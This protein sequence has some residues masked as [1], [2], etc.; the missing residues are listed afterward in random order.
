MTKAPPEA[1][2]SR[3]PQT[4]DETRTPSAF[5]VEK[6]LRRTFPSN[7][8]FTTEEGLAP[9][10]RLLIAYS[11]RNPAVGYCQSMNFLAAVLL[12]HLTEEQAFWVLAALIEDI[13]P[14]DYYSVS[15]LGSRVDQQVFQSCLAWKL[16]ALYR[17][18]KDCGMMLEPVTCSWLMC[19]YINTLP[20]SIV[21][22]VWDCLLWEGNIV[23]LRIGLAICKIQEEK[24]FRGT[25]FVSI[26]RILKDPYNTS[27]AFGNEEPMEDSAPRPGQLSLRNADDVLGAAFDKKWLGSLPRAKIEHLRREF[28]AVMEKNKSARNV[29]EAAA[30]SAA[31]RP[32]AD[33]GS[34]RAGA[35][36]P[37]TEAG[38]AARAEGRAMK[39]ATLKTSLDIET[40]LLPTASVARRVTALS[41]AHATAGSSS[42]PPSSEPLSDDGAASAVLDEDREDER[43]FRQLPERERIQE[44]IALVQQQ[45]AEEFGGDADVADAVLSRVLASGAGEEDDDEDGETATASGSKSSASGAA[46]AA[47]GGIFSSFLGGKKA[48]AVDSPEKL[49]NGDDDDEEDEPEDESEGAVD[50][51]GADGEPETG[52]S[53][54]PPARRTSLAVQNLLQNV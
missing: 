10:R 14:A 37:E 21:L 9:L 49:N 12:L 23:L 54:K 53:F 28:K 22:R 5:E 16:P 36:A 40:S 52:A 15:M 18:F 25:D 39:R 24:L 33:E 13:L 26:Y 48:A 4:P 46:T 43:G 11:V 31:P 35:A 6:D 50:G 2:Y 1:Q 45:R 27:R 44:L 47:K 19:L 7:D 29:R 51:G 32:A 30:S 42:A 20:L 41:T 34:R 17:H 8:N 3:L 38:T